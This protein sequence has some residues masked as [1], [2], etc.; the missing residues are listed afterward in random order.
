VRKHIGRLG[1]IAIICLLSACVSKRAHTLPYVNTTARGMVM[2]AASGAA[3]GSLAGFGVPIGTAIGGVAGTIIGY[4]YGKNLTKEE[5]VENRLRFYG[6]QIV[7]L[8]EEHKLVIPAGRLF[9][10]D[11]P[12]LWSKAPTVLGLVAQYLKHYEKVAVTIS[13]FTDNHRME[14]RNQVLSAAR[15]RQVMNYL[16][17]KGIDSRLMF[18]VGN[19]SAYPLADNRTEEGRLINRRVEIAFRMLPLRRGA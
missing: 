1:F 18:A 7:K 9:P 8:G 15:S 17:R 2:G 10:Q 19:G 4:D 14:K 11:S 16:W 5:N 3:L 13:T 12:R 6:V